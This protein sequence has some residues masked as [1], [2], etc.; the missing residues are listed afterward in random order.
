VA[1]LALDVQQL[2]TGPVPSQLM[3]AAETSEG[4]AE[5]LPN[6]ATP[7]VWGL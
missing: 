6:W 1:E 3:L 5:E 4:V 7:E 2:E